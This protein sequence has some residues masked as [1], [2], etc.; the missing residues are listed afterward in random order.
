MT[1]VN[2]PVCSFSYAITNITNHIRK[3]HAGVHVTQDA[4]A[5]SG[6]VACS[7]GQV[8]LNAV[9]LRKHQGIRHCQAV[10]PPTP[11]ETQPNTV[12]AEPIFQF[13]APPS[14]DSQAWAAS[15]PQDTQTQESSF[16]TQDWD[17]VP[18]VQ[19]GSGP[20]SPGSPRE[21]SLSPVSDIDSPTLPDLPQAEPTPPLNPEDHHQEDIPADGI[22][23]WLGGGEPGAEPEP[24]VEP[25]RML[26]ASAADTGTRLPPVPARAPVQDWD[27]P[28]QLATLL[29]SPNATTLTYGELR[30]DVA[31]MVEALQDI[32]CESIR[33]SAFGIKVPIE[34]FVDPAEVEPHPLQHT[35]LYDIGRTVYTRSLTVLAPRTRRGRYKQYPLA[36]Q[37]GRGYGGVELKWSRREDGLSHFKAYSKLTHLLK[38]SA[39]GAGKGF[40][41]MLVGVVKNRITALQ[42]WKQRIQQAAPTL[43]QGIRLELTVQAAT[44]AQ[45]QEAAEASRYL[46]AQFLFSE[47]AGDKQLIT[48]T[49]SRNAVYTNVDAMLT[50]AE[51]KR[52]FSGEGAKPS[53]LVQ[54][55]AVTDLYNAIGW[56]PGRKPTPLDSR[57][58]WWKQSQAATALEQQLERFQTAAQ[59][60]EL[61]SHL[62]IHLRCQACRQRGTYQRTGRADA[63]RVRCNRQDCQHALSKQRFRA[64]IAREAEGGH[65]TVNLDALV[66]NVL[67]LAF[68]PQ[69]EGV[70]LRNLSTRQD[71]RG[72]KRSN[73]YAT[74]EHLLLQCVS[75]ML[76][77]EHGE[78]SPAE[79]Q[80]EALDWLRDYPAAVTNHL[81]TASRPAADALLERL[82]EEGAELTLPEEMLL[83]HGIAGAFDVAFAHLRLVR[84]GYSCHVIPL[85]SQGPYLGLIN[86]GAHSYKI[87]TLVQT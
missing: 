60:R 84:M 82:A 10:L 76:E 18:P 32:G 3:A 70:L 68:R 29:P 12:A 51:E 26:L 7:C 11:P 27:V 71:L 55:Q 86:V 79:I 9:A 63:F 35:N 58:A 14:P 25:P 20:A 80:D 36:M 75:R 34:R 38:A 4:A 59:A 13:Q 17:D 19:P 6:L 65:L 54:R 5:A 48:H 53:T 57:N 30:V 37:V 69:P 40:Q 72:L 47:D 33:M 39:A 87:L 49:F 23:I 77:Q 2:C 21:P 67:E 42:S 8:V 43:G 83:L 28:P 1:S 73:I 15:P 74:V 85:D 45:A 81:G 66:A 22:V 64:H 46:D 16:A 62:Q 56:N 52:L 31:I 44:L 50:I 24:P 78:Q 61:F 41:P